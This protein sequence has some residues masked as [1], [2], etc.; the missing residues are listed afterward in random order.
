M[1]RSIQKGFTLIEL[2]IVVAIIGILAAIALPA[3]QDYTVRTRISEGFSLAQPARSTLA[4]DGSA[5]VADYRRVI[6]AWNIQAGGT[7]PCA[8]GTGANSKFVESILFSNAAGAA[9]TDTADGTAGEN[10]TI[11]YRDAA[12]GGITNTTRILQLYPRI[13]AGAA[14]DVPLTLA[15]AWTAGTPGAIDWACVGASN[16][17]ALGRFTT[18][19]PAALATGVAARFA[20]A[21]CR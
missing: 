14:A 3:Y 6:C 11:L 2:M 13:R 9:L 20:P 21:E 16:A 15:A 5:A 4:T 10:I 18:V 12:V 8:A 7:A 19:A 17:T 1:K